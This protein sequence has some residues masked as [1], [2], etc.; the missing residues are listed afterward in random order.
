MAHIGCKWKTSLMPRT[1]TCINCDSRF[2]DSNNVKL[3][4]PCREKNKNRCFFC[5]C[6]VDRKNDDFTEG[7]H[8]YLPS[9]PWD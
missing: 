5:G 2:M 4:P 3:C 6:E 9:R 8:D 7:Y 1:I